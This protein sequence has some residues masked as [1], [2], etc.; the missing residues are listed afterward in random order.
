M[1][2]FDSKGTAVCGIFTAGADIRIDSILGN[3]P[4]RH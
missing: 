1:Q 4:V 2:F 3:A